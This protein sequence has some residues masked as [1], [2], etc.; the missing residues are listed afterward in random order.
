MSD[1]ILIYLKTYWKNLGK[2]VTNDTEFIKYRYLDS[3]DIDSF[4]IVHFIIDIEENFN[5]SIDAD[6]TESD[7]FRYIGGLIGIIEKKYALHKK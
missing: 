2:H 7:E 4:E 5:I 6:D 3:G 1:E